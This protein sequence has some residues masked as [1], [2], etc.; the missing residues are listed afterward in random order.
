MSFKLVFLVLVL[1]FIGYTVYIWK[2]GLISTIAEVN[3]AWT[4]WL[5]PAASQIPMIGP[6]FGLFQPSP[7]DGLK[8]D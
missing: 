5:G 4:G 3:G 7:V 2:Q 1:A 6:F 8:H